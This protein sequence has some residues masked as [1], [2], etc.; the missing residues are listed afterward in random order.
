MKKNILLTLAVLVAVGIA[1]LAANAVAVTW[2]FSNQ[3]L[4][5]LQSVLGKQA[6]IGT[7]TATTNTTLTVSATSTATDFILSL[8]NDTGIQVF[9]VTDEGLV[10]MTGF[11][12]TASSTLSYLG[13][14]LVGANS[15]RLYD[16]ASS[17]LFGYTPLNPTRQLTIAG[18]AGQITSSAGAQDLSADR[19]WTLSL[20]NHVIF[21]GSFQA[22]NATTT[23]ATT[24]SLAILNLTSADCDVKST[25]GGIVYCG[26]DATGGGGTFPFTPLTNFN[27]NTSATT[28]ALWLQGSPISLMASSTAWFDQINV[29]STTSGTMATSTFYGNINIIGTASS[30]QFLAGDGTVANPAFSFAKRTDLGIYHSAPTELGFVV[31]GVKQVA[32][33]SGGNVFGTTTGSFLL[34]SLG[35]VSAPAYTFV[36][37][38][39]TG[40]YRA[41]AGNLAFSIDGIEAARFDS[42]QRFGLGT[43]TPAWLTQLATSSVGALFRGG[44]LALTDTNAGA[45]LKHWLFASMGGNLYIGTSTD[46]YATSTTPALTILPNG[47]VSTYAV[48]PATSTAMQIDWN[49]TPNQVEVQMGGAAT[50]IALINATTSSN[51]GSR[52]LVYVC[53]PQS[54]A[55][56]LTWVGIRWIG[57]APTQTTTG[58][59]CDVYSFDITRATSTSAYIVAGTAGTGLK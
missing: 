17:T 19:T 5:P 16:F 49:N 51:W 3:I 53:N 1:P 27:Q 48:Q 55:G 42:S 44:Q 31:S 37:D 28:T 47:Q 40:M 23:N 25:T 18:T 45:N 30:T 2:D 13:S 35:L 59:Q 58:N 34:K 15:G 39:N 57:T 6:A 9:S 20:P 26:T 21:P 4:K 32:I 14:G 43:T 36:G 50:T 29:G 54:T 7:T 56:A 33:D 8:L 41:A 52:K 46:A 22:G 12:S 38:A 24:T 11:I 10:S